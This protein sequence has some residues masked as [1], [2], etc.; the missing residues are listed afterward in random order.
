[1]CGNCTIYFGVLNSVLQCNKLPSEYT[2]YR[3]IDVHIFELCL[4]I[5]KYLVKL[6]IELLVVVKISA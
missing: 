4:Q 6:F 1:M 5:E 3:Q 2:K